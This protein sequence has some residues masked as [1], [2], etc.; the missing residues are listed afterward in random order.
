MSEYIS[1]YIQANE[2]NR[3]H[4]TNQKRNMLPE[5]NDKTSKQQNLQAGAKQP[6]VKLQHPRMWST[7]NQSGNQQLNLQPQQLRPASR[8]LSKIE[9]LAEDLQKWQQNHQQTNT[10]LSSN[11]STAQQPKAKNT[12]SQH[13]TAKED[14]H[15]VF[16]LQQTKQDSQDNLREQAIR[17]A[18][19]HTT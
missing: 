9:Q 15:E 8:G 7:T 10:A 5:Q 3:L 18:D 14:K 4:W 19:P 6:L 11:H 13:S 2:G 17:P 16:Q 1:M 12:S